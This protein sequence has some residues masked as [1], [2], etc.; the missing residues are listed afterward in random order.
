MYAKEGNMTAGTDGKTIDGFSTAVIDRIIAK[1]KTE[2]YYPKPVK[3]VHIPKKNGKTRPLGIPTFEDKLVQEVI[4]QL[5]EAI[6]EPLFSKNSHGFRPNKSC[7]TALHQIKST[8]KGASW[9][10]E[11]DIKGCFDNID[12]DIL[13]SLLA[14][15]IKDGRFIEL[16]RRF[17]KRAL[18]RVIAHGG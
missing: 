7:Q 4:R 18:K 1:M 17:L 16:V 8:A 3:R 2:T 13:L 11:G 6:Y 12:H 15:K 10:V 14:R 9:V 5:L